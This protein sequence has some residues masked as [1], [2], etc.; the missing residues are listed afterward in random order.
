VLIDASPPTVAGLL[1]DAA[2]SAAALRR[3]GHRLES[4]VRLLG[5]GDEVG[6]TLRLAPRVTVPIRIG[7][8]AVSPSGME[9]V[10]VTGPLTELTQT[11]TLTATAAG[12]LVLE[13]IRWAVPHRL[14]GPVV[15]AVLLRRFVLRLLAARSDVLAARA[16]ALRA[17][18]VVVATALRSRATAGRADRLLIAQRTRPPALAGRWE[19]PGGRVEPGETEAEAVVRECR[20]ELGV[21]VRVTG[22]LGTDLP[23]DTGM[24]RV[25][26]A[27]LPPGAPD[28]QPLEHAG[29]RWIGKDEVADVDWVDADRGVV[30]ELI[31]LL[32][33]PVTA[34]K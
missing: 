34:Q 3:L 27:E 4:G 26:T 11:S 12:T 24:L 5:V 18:P 25:H 19:L 8:R 22:R 15:D 6:V 17:E 9:S 33:E 30:P 14:L 16:A 28:P 23:L 29:L 32:T 31:A 2:T 20:E 1:R 21:P 13:E 7:V 10:Q